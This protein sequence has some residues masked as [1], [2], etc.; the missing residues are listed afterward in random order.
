MTMHMHDP[1]LHAATRLEQELETER[2]RLAQA[3]SALQD[4]I[5]PLAMVQ[6]NLHLPL[7]MLERAV[8][9]NPLAVTLAGAG[10]A[11]LAFG[12]SGS[13][14]AKEEAARLMRRH[15][16]LTRWED[17][18]G[19]PSPEPE[20]AEVAGDWLDE[21]E[22]LRKRALA[23]LG[24]LDDA[25]Q[26]KLTSLEAAARA[27]AQV[28]AD[29]THDLR[30]TMGKGL[31]DLGE[32]AREK[33]LLAREKLWQARL[34]ATQAVENHPLTSVMIALGAGLALG[35]VFGPSRG[36]SKDGLSR[37]EAGE[38]LHLMRKALAE[39]NHAAEKRAADLGLYRQG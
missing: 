23:S 28:L 25:A 38:M 17:E 22:A 2:R 27:K 5:S 6:D 37:D 1:E 34:T 39:Q 15:E 18:G 30:E 29:L 9:R 4:K 24:R 3:L 12:S 21:A 36:K 32:A 8:R 7:G 10:L 20:M 35:T 13:G 11:W 26:S 31:S 14:K 33:T 16:D 19:P